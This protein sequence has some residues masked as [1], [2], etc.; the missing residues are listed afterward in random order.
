M[1]GI[2]PDKENI[3]R[4]SMLC[5]R[6]AN[7]KSNNNNYKKKKSGPG[8]LVDGHLL[9][10]GVDYECITEIKLDKCTSS[11]PRGDYTIFSENLIF[12]L[13]LS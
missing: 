9:S 8:G 13:Y 12:F 11:L 7:K 2:V 3:R 6:S 5:R 4:R 1:G 10:L